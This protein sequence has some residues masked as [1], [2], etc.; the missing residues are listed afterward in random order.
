M[1]GVG[2]LVMAENLAPH[3]IMTCLTKQH[4]SKIIKKFKSIKKIFP[5]VILS[6]GTSDE[7][8]KR[9]NDILKENTFF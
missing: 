1:D 3:Q 4:D 2:E 7:D 6:T 8:Y 5:Q 9:L